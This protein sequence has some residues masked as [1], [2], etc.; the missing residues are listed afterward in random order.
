MLYLVAAGYLMAFFI[1]KALNQFDSVSFFVLGFGI[2]LFALATIHED[3]KQLKA[4]KEFNA[5]EL[6]Y[7][8]KALSKIEI[9]TSVLA[10]IAAN[11]EERRE[12]DEK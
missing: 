7:I 12:K 6:F 1:S 9:D 8:R 11:R 4:W 2:L 10:K 5:E 3:L